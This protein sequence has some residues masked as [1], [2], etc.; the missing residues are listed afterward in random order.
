MPQANAPLADQLEPIREITQATD[1]AKCPI[2]YSAWIPMKRIEKE[3]EKATTEQR[4]LSPAEAKAIGFTNITVPITVDVTNKSIAVYETPTPR[5]ALPDTFFARVKK[6][7]HIF[8]TDCLDTWLSSRL[9]PRSCPMCRDLLPLRTVYALSGS[10]QQNLWRLLM[11]RHR[12]IS[13]YI[14]IPRHLAIFRI[15]PRH[16]NDAVHLVPGSA[17]DRAQ[18]LHHALA[19]AQAEDVF[20]MDLQLP[21][22]FE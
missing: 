9:Q 14:D 6:C 21:R 11:P 19:A 5:E 16:E 22:L 10:F 12:E 8:H 15:P 4:T 1:E 17:P 2:C 3:T 20:D 7:G 13:P 18:Q